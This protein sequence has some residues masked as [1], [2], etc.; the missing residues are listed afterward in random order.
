MWGHT[1]RC[2]TQLETADI[3]CHFQ[4]IEYKLA[5]LTF[6]TLSQSARLSL[7]IF[8]LSYLTL[9]LH[10]QFALLVGTCFPLH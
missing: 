9:K 6:K 4:R 8:V 5:S 1:K 2:A 10:L 3:L 7:F